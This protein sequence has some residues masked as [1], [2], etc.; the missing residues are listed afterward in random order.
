MLIVRS[1]VE[2]GPTVASVAGATVSTTVIVGA[3]VAL[4][5]LGSVAVQLPDETPTGNVPAAQVTEQLQLS[6][7]VAVGVTVA[8]P[9]PVHSTCRFAQVAT[10]F[11]PSCTR[12]Y[13][14]QLVAPPFAMATTCTV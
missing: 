14:L 12:R 1:H 9:P 10:G 11:S 8:L 5:P 2:L 13:E 3:Q 6:A 4:F 7:H